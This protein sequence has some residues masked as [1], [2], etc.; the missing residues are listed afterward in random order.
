[1]VNHSDDITID[2][3][4][5]AVFFF[6]ADVNRHP[7]WMGGK[8]ASAMTEGPVQAGYRYRYQTDEGDMELEVTDFQPGR[9]FSART[10]WGPFRWEGTFE[11]E[12]D[13][14]GRSRVRS[15]GSLRLTGIRRI[16]EPFMGGEVR[17]REREEL[18]RLKALAEASAGGT[19][20]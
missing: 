2:R 10:V 9:S 6:V 3:P 11:V 4:A 1:M 20:G 15:S 8:G 13:G 19:G 14:D 7:S 12:P 5:D 17:R 16:L 18:V